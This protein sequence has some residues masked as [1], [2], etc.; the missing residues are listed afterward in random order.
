MLY[1]RDWIYWRMKSFFLKAAL[2]AAYSMICA[3]SQGS[4]SKEERAGWRRNCR[5]ASGYFKT[6]NR[7]TA[8]WQG[9]RTFRSVSER[10]DHRLPRGEST[11]TGRLSKRPGLQGHGLTLPWY[12]YILHFPTGAEGLHWNRMRLHRSHLPARMRPPGRSTL[13]RLP[14]LRWDTFVPA[15]G[16]S[17]SCFNRE[18][19]FLQPALDHRECQHIFST[20]HQVHNWIYQMRCLTCKDK[21]FW[22]NSWL[23]PEGIVYLCRR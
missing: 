2:F 9:R 7:S 16:A 8:L 23:V 18:K 11:R 22:E 21:I 5:P 6:C 10:Q 15:S 4:L 1:S 3:C 12:R 20:I 17:W 13:H 19:G 14:R